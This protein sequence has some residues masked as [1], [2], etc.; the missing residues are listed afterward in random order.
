MLLAVLILKKKNLFSL[1]LDHIFLFCFHYAA[2]YEDYLY[3]SIIYIN[4][5][6]TLSVSV[7]VYT[8]CVALYYI[9]IHI[10]SRRLL[11]KKSRKRLRRDDGYVT[12]S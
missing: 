6:E 10:L 1:Y 4:F 3:T 9:G 7:Y 8:W 11:C 5:M 12:C 2:L